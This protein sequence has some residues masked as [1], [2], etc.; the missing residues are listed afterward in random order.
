MF[1]R[2]VLG[3]IS[4]RFRGISRFGGNFAGFRGNTWISRV[5]NRAKYQKPCLL[6]GIV[7][8]SAAIWNLSNSLAGCSTIKLTVGQTFMSNDTLALLIINVLLF[9]CC[10]Y[11]NM[12]STKTSQSPAAYYLLWLITELSEMCFQ[13]FK[14]RWSCESSAEEFYH[15]RENSTAAHKSN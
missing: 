15:K 5:R 2:H 13:S 6:I 12:W 4:G 11:H 14:C 3:N 10:F 7:L 1:C 9:S 8:S